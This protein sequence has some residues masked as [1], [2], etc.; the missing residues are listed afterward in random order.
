MLS[1]TLKEATTRRYFSTD[2]KQTKLGRSGKA[3]CFFMFVYFFN[4]CGLLSGMI[5]VSVKQSRGDFQCESISVNFN[6]DIWEKAIV[7]LPNDEYEKRILVYSY[8]S[9]VYVQDD[10]SHDGRPVYIERSKF[11]AS[12]FDTISP[13]PT[14]PFHQVKIPAKIQYCKDIK[15]WVFI[16][17][18]IRKSKRHDS[19]CP[20]LLRSETTDAYDI[21]DVQG[22]WQ[23][24]RGLIETTDVQISCNECNDDDDCNLNGICEKNG[25]CEC[26]DDVEG[27][28]FL[29]TQCEVI[30]E[31]DCRTI[32]GGESRRKEK[33]GFDMFES[34]RSIHIF[35][36]HPYF[37]PEGHNETFSVIESDWFGNSE[38]LEEY[39]R[40]A[41]L[42]N[43]GSGK[44]LATSIDETSYSLYLIF[45]GSR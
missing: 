27:M 21:E 30:L 10:T 6:E 11:D 25:R 33:S 7:K 13:Y 35:V 15:S 24:W 31:N 37:F 39:N 22:P 1:T 40:P 16:H 36:F 4:L 42:Y 23:V 29:G 14:K 2:F 12:E 19:D 3:S 45:A 18:N 43:R 32:I 20:W 38:V 9:G 28:T 5:Y 41:Y 34:H 8:F 26:F 17:E 44:G